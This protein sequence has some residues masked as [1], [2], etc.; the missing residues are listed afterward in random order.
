MSRTEA[1]RGELMMSPRSRAEATTSA[2]DL[3]VASKARRSA[4]RTCWRRPSPRGGGE[5][6]RGRS[7]P[8]RRGPADRAARSPLMGIGIAA[9]VRAHHAHAH[10]HEAEQH[11]HAHPHDK[12]HAHD[13]E[14]PEPH[15][16]VHRH[17]RSSTTT[18][19]CRTCTTATATDGAPALSGSSRHLAVARASAL[20]A[21]DG[22]GRSGS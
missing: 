11:E 4:P 17:G 13:G 16:H 21:E 12:H 9:I 19:T 8:P 3:R 18:P 7:R 2:S 15:S 10:L 22:W 1:S 14:V 20:A 5:R 6:P